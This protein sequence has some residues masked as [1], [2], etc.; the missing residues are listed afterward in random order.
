MNKKPKNREMPMPVQFKSKYKSLKT[1][2]KKNQFS[3]FLEI[4]LE[5]NGINLK[6]YKRFDKDMRL[7][8][9][10]LQIGRQSPKVNLE[11]CINQFEMRPIQTIQVNQFYLN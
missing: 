1:S 3:N 5:D 8:W 11:N 10:E 4:P 6:R 9:N 7:K 2:F